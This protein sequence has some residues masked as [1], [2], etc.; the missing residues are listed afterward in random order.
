MKGPLLTSQGSGAGD[1]DPSEPGQLS[2]WD[3]RVRIQ[4]EAR[5]WRF[6]QVLDKVG[7]KQRKRRRLFNDYTT[8]NCEE[9][10]GE[11]T[12]KGDSLG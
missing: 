3:E 11:R 4:Q 1:E 5:L 6:E 8:K 10:C 7:P 2:L 12:S 9:A